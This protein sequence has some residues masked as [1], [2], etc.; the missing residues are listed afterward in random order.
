LRTTAGIAIAFRPPRERF[1]PGTKCPKRRA[2]D[3]A[4]GRWG[5]VAYADG[6]LLGTCEGAPF[7]LDGVLA[8]S[9]DKRT[10]ARSLFAL[11]PDTGR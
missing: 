5:Y 11:E 3:G 10:Q 4:G 9:S 1:S 8:F 7:P 6:A 2:K